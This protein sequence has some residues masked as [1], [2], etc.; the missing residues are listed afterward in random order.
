MAGRRV[1]P[2]DGTGAQIMMVEDALIHASKASFLSGGGEMG[3][4][5]RSFDWA[6]NALGEPASWPQSLRT[7]VRLMLTTN[8]PMFIFWGP[9]HICLYNDAYSTALGPEKHPAMLGAR[10]REMWDEIWDIIGPQIDLVMGGRGATRHEDQL[11]PIFRHGRLDDVYWTY[12][13]SPIDDEGASGTRRIRQPAGAQ[14]RRGAARR[15]AF[16]R[17]ESGWS[18]RSVVGGAGPPRI[19]TG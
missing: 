1:L 18:R 6:A 9:Q 5:I 3:A 14:K 17:L 4:R 13:Y 19:L 12:S 10:G 2:S 11:A 7:V 8:H 15:A 16:L